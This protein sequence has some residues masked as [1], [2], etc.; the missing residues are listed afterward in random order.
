MAKKP[1]TPTKEIVYLI[2][3]F[4]IGVI[5]LIVQP[6]LYLVPETIRFANVMSNWLQ[7]FGAIVV[8]FEILRGPLSKR[9]LDD[10][11]NKSTAL[12]ILFKEQILTETDN[13][14]KILKVIEHQ[15]DIFNLKKTYKPVRFFQVTVRSV[16]I[17][18]LISI[19]LG[20]FIQ[21]VIL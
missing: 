6:S 1:Y 19:I 20:Y 13:S 10:Y 15:N 16:Y 7:L 11:K 12:S 8:S 2:L 3:M 4:L 21:L 14:L 9:Q 18:G 17:L 5:V